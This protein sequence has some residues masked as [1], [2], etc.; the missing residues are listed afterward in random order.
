MAKILYFAQLVDLL[1]R[2]SEEVTLPDSARDVRGLLAWLRSRGGTWER[3]LVE[4]AVRVTIDR[5]FGDLDSA[6][7]DANEIAIINSRRL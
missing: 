1:G 5:Q 4:D 2:A 6:L 3:L 7:S